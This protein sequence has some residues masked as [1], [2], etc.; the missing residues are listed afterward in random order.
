MS[1]GSGHL[2]LI[3]FMGSGKT[4]VGRLLADAV[5]W[6]WVDT[7]AR[8]VA[9]EGRSIE[10]I[11]A[12]SGEARFRAVE[13]EVLRELEPNER[14]V[15]ATGGGLFG[16]YDNRDWMRKNGRTVWLD[17]PLETIRQRLGGGAGRPLWRDDSPLAVRRLFEQRR[18]AYALADLAIE[19]SEPAE[20]AV[21]RV[22]E[23]FSRF[24]R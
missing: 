3:G 12:E 16:A 5:G 22:L 17:L 15:V 8:V 23:H 2:F 14:H 7:D 10:R 1:E 13:R 9:R 4:T 21:K 24:F 11:F 19:A 20:A 6:T 18:A